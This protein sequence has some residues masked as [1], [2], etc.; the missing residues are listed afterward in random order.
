MG[1]VCCDVGRAIICF[2]EQGSR[3]G[4]CRVLL[5]VRNDIYKY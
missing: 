1:P 2:M 5:D 3:Y 4:N